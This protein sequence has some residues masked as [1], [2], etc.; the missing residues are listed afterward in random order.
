LK[1]YR[2]V[3]ATAARASKMLASIALNKGRQIVDEQGE[4]IF[5]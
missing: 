4:H 2:F 5:S 3:R 1:E